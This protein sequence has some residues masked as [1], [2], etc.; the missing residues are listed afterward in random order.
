MGQANATINSN[1]TIPIFFPMLAALRT[2]HEMLHDRG[3]VVRPEYNINQDE[4]HQPQ[5]Q[6]NLAVVA[7]KDGAPIYVFFAFE[8]KLGVKET[9]EF[10]ERM[11]TDQVKQA[12]LVCVQP[13]SHKSKEEL[14]QHNVEIFKAFDL[15]K[16][17]TRHTLVPKHEVL[18]DDEVTALCKKHNVTLEKLPVYDKNDPIVRYYGW[19]VGTVVRIYRQ[20]GA[21]REPEIY[22]RI[23]RS[24]S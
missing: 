15:F 1:K 2:V 7:D 16:N 11:N 14:E 17:K 22:Y 24:L 21:Q 5:I 6:D 8:P 23:V 13:P 18:N 3:F 4:K 9:R 10:I 19:K 12:I 20:Y